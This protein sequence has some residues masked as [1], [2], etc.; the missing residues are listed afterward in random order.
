MLCKLK[1]ER[2]CSCYDDTN[3]KSRCVPAI[4][5]IIALLSVCARYMCGAVNTEDDVKDTT[6]LGR[7]DGLA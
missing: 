4:G 7:I 3:G 5:A 2:G 1:F 6:Q